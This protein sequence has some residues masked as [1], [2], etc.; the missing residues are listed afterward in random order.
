MAINRNR[1]AMD[2]HSHLDQTERQ[3][4]TFAMNLSLLVG[5]ALL[6]LKM[7]AW[8]LTASP[9]IFSDAAE[10]VIHVVAVGFAVYSLRLS[11]RPPDRRFPFGYEKIAFFSAGV[12]GG[13][14][15]LAALAILAVA[16]PRLVSGEPAENLDA[17]MGLVLAASLLTGGLG[18]YLIKLG[19]RQRSLVL[20]ANGR[21]VATDSLTSFGVV[22]GLL[23][24]RVTGWQILD[25]LVAIAVAAHILHSGI[26]MLRASLG[27]LMDGID[28]EM[29]QEIRGQLDLL[30]TDLGVEYH[31]LRMRN[32]GRG[33]NVELH[34]L[35]PYGMP[36]G[37]AHHIATTV[38]ERLAKALPYPVYVSSHLEAT[39]D[40]ATVHPEEQTQLPPRGS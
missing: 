1:S 29:D 34:L 16:V 25:P 23:L 33:V 35:L 28:P 20:E 14:I 5:F 13:L 8:W 17:G 11:F 32:M 18:W 6:A 26:Q 10:S 22:A 37:D 2:T 36:L 15:C 39:E 9:A 38:E 4:A 27:G 19:K 3:R 21:H 31:A 24:V 7:S 30:T 40:H 12:E